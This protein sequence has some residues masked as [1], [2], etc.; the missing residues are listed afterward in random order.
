VDLTHY[1]E[2]VGWA[3]WFYDYEPTSFPLLQCF[4]PDM[5]GKSPWEAGC[6]QWAIDQQPQLD[7]HKE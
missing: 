2:D 7:K 1:K 4:W 3:I 5:T 6:K